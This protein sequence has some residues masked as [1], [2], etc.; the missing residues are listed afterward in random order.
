M[1]VVFFVL[2]AGF[3]FILL[4]V[5]FFA[6]IYAIVSKNP[7]TRYQPMRDD[8]GSFIKSQTQLT[9]ELDALGATARGDPRLGYKLRDLDGDDDSMSSGS[10]TKRNNN[11]HD[12]AGV[13]L[14]PS[15]AGSGS[16]LNEKYGAA[17]GGS[18]YAEQNSPINASTPFIPANAPPR[19]QS[20]GFYQQGSQYS[21]SGV[22]TPS[23]NRSGPRNYG[24]GGPYER[25][26]SLQSN[27][28]YRPPPQ[29]GPPAWQRG[30]GYDN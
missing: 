2:N 4:L 30:A 10:F 29:Q 12:P 6:S 5:V 11:P 15:T 23:S 27:T 26:N 28:A 1:G 19:H 14:P 18:G 8:R 24:A 16:R 17:D 20:P 25:N 22:L 9:T 7:D 13:P 21:G 3:A